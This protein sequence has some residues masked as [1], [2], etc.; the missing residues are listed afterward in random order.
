MSKRP[1]KQPIT[2]AATTK[3]SQPAS[4]SDTSTK[5][6]TPRDTKQERVLAMLR[7]AAG[8]TITTIMKLTEWQQHSVRGFL[9]GVVKKKLKLKIKSE[10]IGNHR[11]YRIVEHASTRSKT[12]RSRP[13]AA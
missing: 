1:P 6:K 8:A 7:S 5:E 13:R 12:A 3:A 2:A 9:A 11:V 10:K 4:A